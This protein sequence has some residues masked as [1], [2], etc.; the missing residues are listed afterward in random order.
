MERK[1]PN[2]RRNLDAAIIRKF[3]HLDDQYRARAII[4]NTVIG[5]LLPD[6]VVKGGS[7]LKLRYGDKE[8]RYTTDL[9]AARAEEL[10]AYIRKL[11]DALREGWNGFTG[12]VVSRQPARPKNV[13]GEYIMQPFDIKLEYNHASWVTVQFELGHDEI[14]DT[15]KPDFWIA[16]EI[17]TMFEELGLP[18]P[19]PV[20]LMPIPH[21]IAQKL[22][23][24]S[25][26]NSER[27][28]D[29][30]DLQLILKNED[31][32]YA[33]TKEACQRLFNSRRLQEWP[34][35]VV[36]VEN[37]NALYSDQLGD[38]DVAQSVDEA[39]EWANTLIKQIE[40]I[41]E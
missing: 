37:W 20:A 9:D 30:I 22:H 10:D 18:A 21:Q 39:V 15:D 38:L 4:A 8:T 36:K 27:A 23:A 33:K 2:S 40:S 5:Q 11:D 16:P 3:G 7:S 26:F 32:D 13:P 17:V 35:K 31:V 29:L 28:H 12:R 1:A 6:G 24:V 34:P 14:G 41:F 25:G 19:E